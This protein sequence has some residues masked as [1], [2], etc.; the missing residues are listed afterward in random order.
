M[1]FCYRDVGSKALTLFLFLSSVGKV[2]NGPWIR[3]HTGAVRV[4]VS[5]R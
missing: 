3:G 4:L 5:D 2:R 1:Q